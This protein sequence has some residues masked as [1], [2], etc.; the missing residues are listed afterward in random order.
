MLKVLYYISVIF[1]S[2]LALLF[3]YVAENGSFTVVVPMTVFLLVFPTL[4]GKD[5][6]ETTVTTEEDPK[7]AVET[8]E[9]CSAEI[10]ESDEDEITLESILEE[11]G[12]EKSEEVQTEERKEYIYMGM[13]AYTKHGISLSSQKFDTKEAAEHFADVFRHN[14]SSRVKVCEVVGGGYGVFADFVQEYLIQ[15]NFSREHGGYIFANWKYEERHNLPAPPPEHFIDK[16]PK[17]ANFLMYGVITWPFLALVLLFEWI[18]GAKWIPNDNVQSKATAQELANM[19]GAEFESYI[20]RRLKGMGYKDVRVTQ[21]SGDFGADVI[22]VNS[23]GETVCIQCKHYSKPVG[24]KA[25]QEIY[26]AK[27]YYNCQK[28]MVITNATYTKAAIDLANK[29]GVD[30]WANFR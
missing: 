27:Q 23:N 4:Y 28:A 11:D 2:A 16:Y 6:S 29:T 3:S 10:V 26:S 8:V 9:Q 17:T 14:Y 5:K 19:T 21:T 13:R 15:S 18:R 1:L 25:V 30:L 24:I 22:A 12:S 7:T 20:G